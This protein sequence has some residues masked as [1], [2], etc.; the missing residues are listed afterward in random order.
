MFETPNFTMAKGGSNFPQ[1]L[2]Q[3]MNF[4]C[5]GIFALQ[6]GRHFK[7]CNAHSSYRIFVFKIFLPIPLSFLFYFWPVIPGRY[8]PSITGKN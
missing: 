6:K 1:F 3:G 2:S 4:Y 8:S 7:I 5:T